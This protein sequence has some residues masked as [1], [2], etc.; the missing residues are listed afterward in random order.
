MTTESKRNG[1]TLGAS[2]NE[3]SMNRSE[4]ATVHSL[5]DSFPLLEVDPP[6]ATEDVARLR[7]RTRNRSLSELVAEEVVEWDRDEHVVRKGRR[8]YETWDEIC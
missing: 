1:A 6:S 8:F 2:G 3:V 7:L 4:R 5:R